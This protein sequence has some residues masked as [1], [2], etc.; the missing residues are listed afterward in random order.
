MQGGGPAA[1]NPASAGV[2]LAGIRSC[3]APD[4]MESTSSPDAV[5]ESDQSSVTATLTAT[6]TPS[7]IPMICLAYPL[8]LLL[9]DTRLC[10]H[11]RTATAWANG[12]SSF[13]RVGSSFSKHM[14]KERIGEEQFPIENEDMRASR[15]VRN[16]VFPCHGARSE[17]ALLSC[18][19][20]VIQVHFTCQ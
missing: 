19:G 11:R 10:S 3:Q 4:G 16:T 2:R 14:T 18:H 1:G 7:W 15:R 5:L 12:L 17:L 6:L 9:G 8:P 13:N 20:G